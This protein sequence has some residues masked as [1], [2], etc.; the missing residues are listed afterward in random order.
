MEEF[1]PLA[2]EFAKNHSLMVASWVAIFIFVIYSFV[3]A[4]FSKV[5]V[6]NN[7]QATNLI[8]NQDGVV[9]DLRSIDDF[10]RGHIAGSQHYLPTDIKNHNLGK[11]EQH[12]NKPVI[13]ACLNGLSARSSASLLVK[14][15]FTQVYVLNE[16][17]AGWNA[18]RLPLIK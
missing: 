13:L 10:K 3:Q 5:K 4:A 16:G 6:V 18:S 2:I 14:Q 15:G 9:I 11:L 8:N 12:K 7:A 1:M 17:I